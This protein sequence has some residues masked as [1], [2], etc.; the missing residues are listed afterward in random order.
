MVYFACE[1]CNE[2][3]KKGRV[4]SHA[5]TCRTWSVTC[6]DCNQQFTI[7]TYKGH[8]TCVT[9]AQRYEGKLYTGSGANKGDAKQAAWLSRVRMHMQDRSCDPTLRGHLERLLSYDNIPRKEKPFVNFL[10]NS[11]RIVNPTLAGRMWAAVESA[12]KEPSTAAEPSLVYSKPSASPTGGC[13]DGTSSRPGSEPDAA[14][15]RAT[16][17]EEN[18][19]GT[20]G[21]LASQPR[22]SDKEA[23]GAGGEATGSDGMA[24][25]E[26]QVE[27][28]QTT[29]DSHAAVGDTK[30]RAKTK[31]SEQK[32]KT[33][34]KKQEKTMKEKDENEDEEK[35]TKKERKKK[36]KSKDNEEDARK[37]TKRKKQQKEV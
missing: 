7:E 36:R 23:M 31:V 26:K 8:N 22:R 6:L 37:K 28:K 10:K 35:E 29:S 18:P 11:L 19:A 3:L 4:E 5:R 13:P 34:K 9:E 17:S 1:R 15:K 16:P 20:N 27:R 30:K 32:K 21:K 33:T 24:K 25:P 2:S 14:G 12:N